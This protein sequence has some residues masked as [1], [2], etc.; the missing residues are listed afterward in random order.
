MVVF[1]KLG[2][3]KCNKTVN[4]R[5]KHPRYKKNLPLYL[6]KISHK[7]ALDHCIIVN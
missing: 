3:E 2:K 5:K 4:N 1:S 7:Q 6:S